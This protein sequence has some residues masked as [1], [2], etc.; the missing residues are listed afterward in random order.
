MSHLLKS[1]PELPL[2][3]LAIG[4]IADTNVSLQSPREASGSRVL[5][6]YQAAAARPASFSLAS[7]TSAFVGAG[8]GCKL[9]AM[10]DSVST[11]LWT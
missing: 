10:N 7:P 2:K 1:F 4:T 6:N 9:Q 3:L 5:D 11:P 8:L